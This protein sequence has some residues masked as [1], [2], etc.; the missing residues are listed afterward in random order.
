MEISKNDAGKDAKADGTK[1]K[2]AKE[3]SKMTPKVVIAVVVLAAIVIVTYFAIGNALGQT[4]Q[5]GDTVQ[6]NY[7]GMFTNGTIFSSN[8][9]VQ[10]STP[11]QFKVGANQVIQGF[12]QAV[13]GMR[14]GQEKNI[15][16]PVNEA[17]GPVNPA[18]FIDIPTNTLE[19]ELNATPTIGMSIQDSN[20]A[21]G[22][23]TAVNSTHTTIDFN[24][25]LAGKTLV[26][27]IVVV[28]IT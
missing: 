22:I 21:H 4:V 25:P 9:G 18:L 6:V 10:N 17:Y 11:L 8:I 15:T 24:S 14:V 16:I 2:K 7:T 27:K 19:T 23:I 13:I 12:D 3:K 5:N 28:S 20:G 1:G 26:F